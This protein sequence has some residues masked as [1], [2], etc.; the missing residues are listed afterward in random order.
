M[1]SLRGR[2]LAHV[3]ADRKPDRVRESLGKDTPAVAL[4]F[5]DPS[6][7][8]GA[9]ACRP[10]ALFLVRPPP[11]G[12]VR[13]TLNV[14]IDRAAE[15]GVEHVVFLS[16]IGADTQTWVPHHDVEQHLLRSKLAWT[17]LRAG[18]FAQNLADAYREDIRSR[19]LLDLPAGRGRVAFVDVRDLAEVA[20]LAFS[21]P[22]LRN[23]AWDLTGPEALSFDSVTQ[24]LS[25]ILCRRI[26]YRRASIPGYFLRCLAR[27]LALRQAAIQTVLH[28]GI[29]FGNAERV[30]PSLERLLGY[31][32]RTLGD[33]VADHAKLWAPLKP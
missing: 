20:A 23:Q 22:S 32:P 27:G 6:T 29:R 5:L 24:I 3:A 8:A 30:D 13:N 10:R 14:L 19:D 9:L 26:R 12:N 4:D 31:R 16:V 15:A 11:I 28:V 2:G 25:G 17:F 18:F 1:A 21:D 7:F 33:Y